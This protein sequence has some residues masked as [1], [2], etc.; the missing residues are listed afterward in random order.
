MTKL[1]FDN[2]FVRE[3]PSDPEPR[4]TRRQVHNACYSLVSPQKVSDPKLVSFAPEVAQLLDLNDSDCHSDEF[5]HAMAGNQLLPGMEPHAMCYGGHQFGNWAGQLGDGRAIV[6]GDV[7]NERGEHWTMQ[8]KGAGP[9]PYSRTADGLAV[10]RSSIREY[11]CSEAMFHLGVPTTRALCLLTTG[12]PVMRDILYDG[13]PADEPGAI[14]CRVAP[15]F[16]RFGSFQLFAARGEVKELAELADYTIKYYFPELLEQYSEESKEI[17]LAWFKQVCD[18]TVKMVVE[19]MRVGFVHGVMNTD[20]MSIL[21]LTI[22]YGPYGWLDNV[23]P[24]WTPNTTDAQHRRYR[25]SQQPNIAL[26]NCYQL[27]NALHSLIQ[28]N[29]PLEEVLQQFQR[30]YQDQWRVMMAGKLGFEAYQEGDDALF[31]QLETLLAEVE[32]DMTLFYRQLSI[33]EKASF[34]DFQGAFYQADGHSNTY[35]EKF[36]KWLGDYH[37]RLE[38]DS[39]AGAER[40]IAMQGVNPLYVFRNYLAQ[41]AIDLAEGGD[42][43]MVSE[44]LDVLRKP[45]DKQAGKERYAQKRPDWARDKVGCSMLS[46]SS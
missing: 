9:T 44:L 4:N 23:D 36:E 27:A 20:N 2:R 8:L 12:E 24:E 7:V 28:E 5:L 33:T 18:L 39:R 30:D 11:L 15:N 42:Y 10:L 41:E 32:T 3:L 6:L 43:S 31:S 35:R 45:Y 21:G 26:W 34:S 1:T 38:Q 14:V 46:C 13:R 16:I 29:E 17:Y 25:Y 40:L 37:H 19:W 22:D